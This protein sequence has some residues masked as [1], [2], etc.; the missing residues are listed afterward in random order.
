MMRHPFLAILL[1]SVPVVAA[2]PAPV[3]AL[4]YHPNGK[5]LAVGLHGEVVLVDSSKGDVVARVGGQTGRVTAVAFSRD[6]GRLAIASGEPAK[7][8]TVRLYTVTEA[9]P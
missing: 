4:A 9:G 1:C 6:G 2:P 7:S 5:L 8:G 3:S